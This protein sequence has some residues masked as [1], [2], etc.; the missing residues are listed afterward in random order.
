MKEVFDGK[1]SLYR[2][3]EAEFLVKSGCFDDG[4]D[5]VNIAIAEC[6]QK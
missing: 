1:M 2:S 5:T 6:W 4:N 3:E